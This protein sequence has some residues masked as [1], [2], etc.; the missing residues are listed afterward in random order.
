M[1]YMKREALTA[2]RIHAFNLG[3]GAHPVQSEVQED[4]LQEPGPD[5]LGEVRGR[6]QASVI[7]PDPLAD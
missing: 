5:L 2:K 3:P 6:K 4:A 7:W 1:A